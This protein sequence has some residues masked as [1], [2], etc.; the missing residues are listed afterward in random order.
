[1]ILTKIEVSWVESAWNMYVPV[2]LGFCMAYRAGGVGRSGA[3]VRVISVLLS[4]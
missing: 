3:P 4:K 1:M 2:N